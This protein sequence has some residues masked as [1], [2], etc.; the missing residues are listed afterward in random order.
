MGVKIEAC[1]HNGNDLLTMAQRNFNFFAHPFGLQ[2]LRRE[3]QQEKISIDDLLFQFQRKFTTAEILHIEE[4]INAP[5]TQPIVEGACEIFPGFSL[6]TDENGW[7]WHGASLTID[8]PL[9]ANY[10]DG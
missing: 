1:F 7:F 5:F 2:R 8:Y 9:S 4:G 6:V 10:S 3:N